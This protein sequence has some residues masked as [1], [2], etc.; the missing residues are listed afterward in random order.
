[1]DT[2]LTESLKESTREKRGKGVR[3]KVAGQTQL[4]SKWTDF[5][6]PYNKEEL[7]TYIFKAKVSEFT[8]P[9]ENIVYMTSGESVAS[10]SWIHQSHAKL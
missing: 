7:F 9:P 6:D 1:M 3:S 4:P 8:F 10:A 5:H 2:Y